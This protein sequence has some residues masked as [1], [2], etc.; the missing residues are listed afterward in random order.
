[1]LNPG[2]YR[3]L[4]SV[5]GLA[6]FAQCVGAHANWSD[7]FDEMYAIYGDRLTENL[8]DFRSLAPNTSERDI[9]IEFTRLVSNLASFACARIRFRQEKNLIV[10]GILALEQ[11]DIR[12]QCDVFVENR[13]GIPLLCT[14]I[15][16]DEVFGSDD[17]W[18]HSS[19][20]VQSM[21]ALYGHHCPVFLFTQRQWKLFAENHDRNA[22]LT[23]PFGS[24]EELSQHVNSSLMEP[25]GH[26]FLKAIY[27][28][29]VSKPA[30]RFDESVR[31]LVTPQRVVVHERHFDTVERVPYPSQSRPSV[32]GGNAK[33]S[34]SKH[35]QQRPMFISGHDKGEPVYS[36]VRIVPDEIV[37]RIEEEISI[38]E[39][40]EREEHLSDPGPVQVFVDPFW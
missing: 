15:K 5:G 6:G 11:Y 7:D 35:F 14:E 24:N 32:K 17:M 21:C 23:E 38:A 27:I 37:Q 16:A 40:R 36:T 12:S 2:V 31:A 10:G 33:Q 13:V 30:S 29:L 26:S 3:N 1:M 19:R 4:Q 20:G 18:Y 39:R 9:S 25:M 34:N 8:D 22:L 28:C